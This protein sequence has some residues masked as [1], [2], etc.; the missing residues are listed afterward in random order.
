MGISGA[1]VMEIIG[2]GSVVT[3]VLVT[4]P[5]LN[6]VGD[7][8]TCIG[9]VSRLRYNLAH[10]NAH[11][12]ILDSH[13]SN[14]TG[15]T[16][17]TEI[18]QLLAGARPAADDWWLNLPQPDAAPASTVQLLQGQNAMYGSGGLRDPFILLAFGEEGEEDALPP[19]PRPRS[20]VCS[21]A[22]SQPCASC[23]WSS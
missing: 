12:L 20:Y 6:H 7:L 11:L 18:V 19:D 4:P 9:E 1:P 17:V 10:E 3:C 16:A 15:S 5:A 13:S 23:S 2:T 22:S 8:R 21:T 14:R